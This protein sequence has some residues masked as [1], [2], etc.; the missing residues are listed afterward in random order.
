MKKL[1]IP[2]CFIL[3]CFAMILVVLRL[4]PVG[5]PRLPSYSGYLDPKTPAEEIVQK[6][7]SVALYYNKN[8]VS[9]VNSMNVVSAMILDYRAYDTLY[10]AVILFTAMICVLSVLLFGSGNGSGS[11]KDWVPSINVMDIT[12]RMVPFILMFGLYIIFR[13][14]LSA[15]GGFQG[16]VIIGAGFIIYTIVFGSEKAGRYIPEGILTIMNSLGMSIF[17]CFGLLGIITGY[18][19]LTNKI[20]GIPPMGQAGVLL[21]SGTLLWI[22]IGI[23]MNVSGAIIR[24]FYAFQK[25]ADG[26]RSNV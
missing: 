24:I 21:S 5:D 11:G 16:G 8:A 14:H 9:D 2:A 10:E 3:L 23:G 17:V 19:F 12:K 4:S 26:E 22:N 18:N 13:G 6:G 15:G 20:A 7:Q 25:N 1:F